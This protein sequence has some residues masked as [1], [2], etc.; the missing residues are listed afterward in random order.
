MKFGRA[1]KF[2]RSLSVA[3]S[4]TAEFTE[5]NSSLGHGSKQAEAKFIVA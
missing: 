3:V 4:T 5:V 2:K 1:F